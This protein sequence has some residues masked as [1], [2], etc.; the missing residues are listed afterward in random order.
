LYESSVQT[1]DTLAHLGERQ[2]MKDLASRPGT[3]A[4]SS[5]AYAGCYTTPER[6]GRGEG[7]NVYRINQKSGVWRHV[8]VVRGLTNP[9]FLT[10]NGQGRHLYAVHGDTDQASAFAIEQLTGERDESHP[11]HVVFDPS[12]HFIPGGFSAWRIGTVTLL[13]SSL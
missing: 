4:S 9:S 1:P 6:D 2:G 3:H 10:L 13:P 8:Q 11:H 12:G 7:I 5:F